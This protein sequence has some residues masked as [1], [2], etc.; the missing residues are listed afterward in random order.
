MDASICRGHHGGVV[1]SLW[2][3]VLVCLDYYTKNSIDWMAIYSRSLFLIV[4]EAGEFK[5]KA[6]ADSMTGENLLFD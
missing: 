4:L 2:V 5:V 1:R 3:P 6:Q